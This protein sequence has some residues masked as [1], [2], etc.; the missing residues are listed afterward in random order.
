MRQTKKIIYDWTLSKRLHLLIWTLFIFY[1]T[2]LVAVIF[3]VFANP[4]V[5][6]VHYAIII[7]MFYLHGDIVLPWLMSKGRAFKSLVIIAVIVQMTV[8]IIMHYLADLAMIEVDL[9]QYKGRYE[10]N[11]AVIA[12]N[13]Y[14]GLYFMGFSTGYYY[15]K[16]YLYER[17]ERQLVENNR[18]KDII[19]IQEITQ[20]LANAENKFLKAQINPHFLFNTL[21]FIYHE[22]QR[23]APLAGEAILRLAQI[24]RYALSSEEKEFSSHLAQEIEQVNN[25]IY[26]NQIVSSREQFV[27]FDYPDKLEDIQLPP[28]ILLTLVENVFKHGEIY[29]EK[30]EANIGLYISDESIVLQTENLA[31]SYSTSEQSNLGLANITRRLTLAFGE[32]ASFQYGLHTDGY[33]RAKVEVK[34]MLK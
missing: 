1:E 15:L 29:D 12:R 30:S 6:L 20:L 14:R 31:K 26:L 18:L 17:R 21:D 2:A 9:L 3:D 32:N 34:L 8:Y 28:L 5:Y 25:L 10:L 27:S 16:K 23:T 22:S 11:F 4:I 24:M 19:R 7:S 33:F 13:L